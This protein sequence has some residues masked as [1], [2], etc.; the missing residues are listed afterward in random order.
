MT[1]EEFDELMEETDSDDID[2]GAL[3]GLNI[4]QKYADEKEDVVSGVSHDQLWSL[5][6][7]EVLEKGLTK[8]DAVA[9]RKLGWFESEDA[10]TI[11]V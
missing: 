10:F 8:E 4:L 5:G 11:F 9:L 2:N 1:R 7:D 6:V 3:R